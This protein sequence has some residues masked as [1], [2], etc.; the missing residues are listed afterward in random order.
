MIL[1]RQ[2]TMKAHVDAFIGKTQATIK[3]LYP[4]ISRHS[5][6]SYSNKLHIYKAALRP[7][8]S[9]ACPVFV[10][11]AETHY[12]RLQILQNKTL[13]MMINLPWR[14]ATTILQ[15]DAN[16]ETVHQY[17]GKLT[18]NFQSSLT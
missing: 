1:D 4:M 10:N 2:L 7:I 12:K 5:K 11:M 15:E 9:Y 8:F 14:Y 16:M 13:K 18:T 6:L 3:L 17:L